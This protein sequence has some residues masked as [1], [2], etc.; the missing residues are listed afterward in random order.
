MLGEG[1]P[2]GEVA[3]LTGIPGEKL[4][5][6][7]GGLVEEVSKGDLRGFGG[8][9]PLAGELLVMSEESLVEMGGD[10]MEFQWTREKL[11][12]EGEKRGIEKGIEKGRKQGVEIGIER[13]VQK[14]ALRMLGEGTPPGEVA[15]L[16]GIPGEKLEELKGGTSGE[17][18]PLETY[19]RGKPAIVIPAGLLDLGDLLGDSRAEDLVAVF[20]DQDVI[21]DPYGDPGIRRTP[22]GKI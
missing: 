5:E 19:R 12:A 14:V 8:R 13:G 9:I 20:G 15:R 11:R 21:L 4:E 10:L 2:P 6:L 1:T 18:R 22:P 7:K 17:A 3:R 16:T